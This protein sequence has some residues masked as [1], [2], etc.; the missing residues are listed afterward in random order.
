MDLPQRGW[1]PTSRQR[2]TLTVAVGLLLVVNPAY[3]GAFN[4]DLTGQTYAVQEVRV[5]DGRI[6]TAGGDYPEEPFD[7]IGCSGFPV[8]AGC[9]IERKQIR[10]G[11]L[12]YNVTVRHLGYDEALVYHTR[13][14]Q[15][16]YYRRIPQDSLRG[17]AARPLRG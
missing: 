1:S 5:E 8:S 12:R 4:L 13:H 11:D 10:D 17:S 6:T 9:A 14:G 16:G 7:G 15:A 3:V 2:V